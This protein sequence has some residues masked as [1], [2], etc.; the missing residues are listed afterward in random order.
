[1]MTKYT[2]DDKIRAQLKGTNAVAYTGGIV[3]LGRLLS[4]KRG[5]VTPKDPSPPK[6]WTLQ[7]PC[8]YAKFNRLEVPE[9]DL[10]ISGD[11]VAELIE[12]AK[13]AGP[14]TAA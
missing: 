10:K 14:H 2:A 3:A 6:I 4:F 8:S 1:M 9:T 13:K 11:T 5:H 12:L 7:P